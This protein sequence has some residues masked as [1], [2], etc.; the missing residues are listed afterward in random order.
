MRESNPPPQ[1][2]KLLLYRLTNPAV[3]DAWYQTCQPGAM[4]PYYKD[5]LA[6][7]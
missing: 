5:A 2:G 4:V 6:F 7:K 1:F 3:L